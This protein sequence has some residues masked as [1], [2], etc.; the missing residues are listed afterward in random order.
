MRALNDPVATAQPRRRSSATS[1]PAGPRP[2]RAAGSQEAP[3]LAGVGVGAELDSPRGSASARSAA[4][5]A[6]SSV[7]KMRSSWILRASACAERASSS[8]PTPSVPATPYRSRRRRRRPRL[9]PLY[10]PCSATTART[11]TSSPA[12][13]IRSGA[14]PLLWGTGH[15]YDRSTHAGAWGH[16]PSFRE[17]VV[18]RDGRWL[19]SPSAAVAGE[20]AHMHLYPEQRPPAGSISIEPEGI[21]R[22]ILYLRGDVDTEVATRFTSSQRPARGR[23]DRRRQRDVHQ[24]S[25]LASR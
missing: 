9:Q 15:G 23:R 3:A 20:E 5:R 21:D 2:R 6:P 11:C 17:P 4:D 7:G 25:G 10:R 13:I 24:P 8:R 12:A 22:R 18:H 19:L 1:S 14:V 16:V